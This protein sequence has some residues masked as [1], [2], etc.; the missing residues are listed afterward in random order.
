MTEDL[1]ERAERAY[2]QLLGRIGKRGL[3]KE[4]GADYSVHEAVEED[5][6]EH[7]LPG[8]VQALVRCY[9]SDLYVADMGECSLRGMVSEG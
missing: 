2:D 1:A 8:D 3:G 7:Q 6:R 9:L 4:V 5:L